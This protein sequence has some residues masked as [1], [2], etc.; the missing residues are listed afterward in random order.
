MSAGLRRSG[1]MFGMAVIT[2][3][4]LG[5]LISLGVWQLQRRAEKHELI[6]A[7]DARLGA[8]PVA[9]PAP[10]DWPAL[11]QQKDEFRRVRLMGTFEARPD[12]R[13][14]TSGSGLRPDAVG[15]GVW[16]FAP[17]DLNAGGT[18]VINRGFMP[19]PVPA[20]IPVP[21]GAVELVGYLRFAEK[22]GS[23]TPDAEVGKRL[24]FAR[25][26]QAMASALGWGKMPGEVAPFYI[27]LEAPIPEGG[28]PKPGALSVK[29]KDD[30]LQYA[31]T[32]FGLAAVVS[33]ASAFWFAGAI[34]SRRRSKLAGKD[35]IERG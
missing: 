32:W 29:L 16:V 11:T 9:V 12:A 30:H 19:E 25:D 18:V 28:L 4:M 24:W 3:A 8:A 1:G 31:M 6:A 23:L 26:H 17:L 33:I 35:D 14:F 7:L 10:G 21:A 27:D 15:T 34:S 2:L 20:A 13:V 5:T 22:P